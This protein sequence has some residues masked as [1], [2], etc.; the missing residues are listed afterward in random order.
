VPV[1]VLIQAC[2]QSFATPLLA[3]ERAQTAV[4]ATLVDRALTP[5]GIT[6]VKA[7]TAAAHEHARLAAVLARIERAVWRLVAVWGVTSGLAQFTLMGMFVQGFWF[8]A[9]LVRRGTLSAGDVMAVFWAC[10]MAATSVQLCIPQFILLAKG[11]FAMESLLALVDA[12]DDDDARDAEA[13]PV[14]AEILLRDVSFAYPAR[15]TQPILRTVT[16][17]LP[18]RQTTFIVGPSG[19][20]KSTIAHLLA[21][22]YTPQQGAIEVDGWGVDELRSVLDVAAVGQG[23]ACV[24]F[25]M[26]VFEN[27]ALGKRGGGATRAEVVAACRQVRMH[28]FI[29]GLPDGYDTLLGAGGASLSGGQKQRLALARVM[30]RDPDVL[31]LGGFSSPSACDIC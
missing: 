15:P 13:T 12:S 19:S 3:T 18:A 16:L 5:A 14:R 11:K 6:A 21:G 29:A 9:G 31:V 20:G 28:D 27:V 30:L 7:C 17:R 26:S 2:S 25:D 8:G 10:L 23:A 1:L 24:L 22:L 4:A